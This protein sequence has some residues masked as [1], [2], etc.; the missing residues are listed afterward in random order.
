M[1]NLNTYD[2]ITEKLDKT[3]TWVDIN[4]KL[5]ISREIKYKPYVSILKRY[6]FKTNSY[7]YFIALLNNPPVDKIFKK[8]IIDD[9]GRIKINLSNIWKET[10]LSQLESNCNIICE[11]VENDKD[12]VI[13][14]IDV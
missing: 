2:N 12:G 11:L 9:Y 7:S 6:D 1:M 4:K 5:L 10:Y 8:T 13:Y 3:K 14:L